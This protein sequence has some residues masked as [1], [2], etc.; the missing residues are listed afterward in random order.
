[1]DELNAVERVQY[2]GESSAEDI[3]EGLR[4][5]LAPIYAAREL[6]ASVT[7]ECAALTGWPTADRPIVTTDRIVLV[8]GNTDTVEWMLYDRD[9]GQFVERIVRNELERFRAATGVGYDLKFAA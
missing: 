3:I 2:T 6:V 5:R 7:D 9:P 1:M 8:V 4:R